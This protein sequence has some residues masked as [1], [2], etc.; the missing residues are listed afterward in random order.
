MD[1]YRSEGGECVLEEEG[2]EV[3]FGPIGTPGCHVSLRSDV[4][5]SQPSL[6]RFPVS[7]GPF[8]AARSA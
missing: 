3:I 6:P 4:T 2:Y 8:P 1:C 7:V 5:A